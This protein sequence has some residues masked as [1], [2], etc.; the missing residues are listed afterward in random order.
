MSIKQDNFFDEKNLI[1]SKKN[2]KSL[3]ILNSDNDNK[4]EKKNSEEVNI[5]K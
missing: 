1:N 3:S 2:N 4:E 5:I